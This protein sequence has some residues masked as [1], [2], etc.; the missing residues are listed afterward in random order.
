MFYG[1]FVCLKGIIN[2]F[3]GLAQKK[4]ELGKTVQKQ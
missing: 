4:L 2:F 3:Q 1:A